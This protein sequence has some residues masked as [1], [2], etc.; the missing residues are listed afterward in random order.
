M[1]KSP[2][3]IIVLGPPGSGKGTQAVALAKR[4]RIPHISTGD[5]FRSHIKRRS[6]TG[7]TVARLL[8]TGTLV[9]DTLVNGIVQKRLSQSDCKRGFVFDGYPRTIQQAQYLQRTFPPSLVILLELPDREVVRRI[10][11]RRL[12]PDGTI[13]HLEYKPPP[14]SLRKK[15]IQRDDERPFVVRHRLKEYRILTK[16]LIRWYADKGILE[17]IDGRP[18]IATIAQRIARTLSRRLATSS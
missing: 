4:F 18:S 8:R 1:A 10:S 12:A 15:L 9:P 3:R 7:K 2:F 17:R 16:P 13:Y 6:L 14:A 11:G 5:I